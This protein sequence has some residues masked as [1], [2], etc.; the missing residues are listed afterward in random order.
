MTV[1][2]RLLSLKGKNLEVWKVPSGDIAV[3]YQ[4]AE[5]KN[6]GFLISEFGVGRTFEDACED[7]ISKISG[8][9]LVFKAYSESR[10]EVTVL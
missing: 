2:E 5:I 7:Y 4:G 10:E 6:N 1:Y 9:T 8:K 3:S